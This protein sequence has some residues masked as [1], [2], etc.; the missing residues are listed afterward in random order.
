M[1]QLF[2]AFALAA[3]CVS[4]GRSVESPAFAI[5]ASAFAQGA[6]AD[7][8]ALQSPLDFGRTLRV[9]YL[10]SGGTSGEA[11]KLDALV[12]EGPW[13][14][15]RSQLIDKTDLGKYVFEVNDRASGRLLYSRGFASIYGE[16]ETVPES[17][18]TN[19]TFHE[20]L[21]FPWPV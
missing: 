7:R 2:A 9:D 17:R 8:S 16:W 20:S 1:R 14:G 19:R 18:R 15:S 6:T 21:R 13:P 5:R 3:A 4:S 10:H 12:S 11:I